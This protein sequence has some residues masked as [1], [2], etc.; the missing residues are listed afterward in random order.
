MNDLNNGGLKQSFWTGIDLTLLFLG[1]WLARELFFHSMI[2]PPLSIAVALGVAFFIFSSL[3]VYSD[4]RRKSWMTLLYTLVS[5]MMLSVASLLVV[6]TVTSWFTYSFVI[7]AGTIQTVL[8]LGLRITVWHISKKWRRPRSVWFIGEGSQDSQAFIQK[9]MRQHEGRVQITGHLDAFDEERLLSVM[10]EV[11]TLLLSPSMSQTQKRMASEMGEK[12][13]KEVLII[14]EMYDL[15][16]RSAHTEQVDDMIVFS[17]R[18]LYISK[19]ER[20]VKRSVDIIVAIMLLV[21]TS[22][23][24]IIVYLMVSMT[25]KGPAFFKQERLGLNGKPFHIYKFRSMVQDAEQ[26]TGPVLATDKDPRITP[27]G[28]MIRATRLDELPQLLNVLKGDMS[29]IGP[30]PEREHFVLLFD[31]QYANYRQRMN[32]KPGITGLAQISGNYTTSVEDK[33]RYDLM[34]VRQYSL[35]LDFRILLQTIR[36]MLQREQAKGLESIPA[37]L[38]EEETA[39]K[40]NHQKAVH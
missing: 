13:G 30:R 1:F 16:I 9:L 40:L 2:L 22:P 38:R 4:W 28:A 12:Y 23:I 5:G 19:D 26:K 11:D 17:I 14:P 8:V 25:S 36:V 32:V 6:T 39:R 31:E 33:L 15:S 24:F 29:L 20:V 7:V 34:Y 21:L 37:V 27:V 18:P 3:D 10:H 35:G